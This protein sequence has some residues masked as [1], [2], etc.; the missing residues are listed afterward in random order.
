MLVVG[1]TGSIGSG[2]TTVANLFAQLGVPVIDADILARDVTQPH[3]PA[4]EKIVAHFGTRIIHPDGSLNRSLLRDIIF[5]ETE[6]RHWLERLLHPIILE[7]MQHD[8]AALQSPY[9]LAV[10]PLLLETDATSFIQ[11]ILVVDV[12]EETQIERA[13]LRDNSSQSKIKSIID[14]QMPRA[15]RLARADDII[16]NAGDP[17]ELTPQ[18]HA[19]H[20]QYLKMGEN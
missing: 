8:I 10:I 11:R 6:S 4:Y 18:V 5:N 1:L 3:T 2:K 7:R 9:C 17:E 13:I 16:N 12:P 20:E 19:L 14:A 15:A